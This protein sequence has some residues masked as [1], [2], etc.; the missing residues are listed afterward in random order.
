V[1]TGPRVLVDLGALYLYRSFS[2]SLSFSRQGSREKGKIGDTG[3]G[4]GCSCPMPLPAL[5]R[6][7]DIFAGG[8]FADGIFVVRTWTQAFPLG[9]RS[10]SSSFAAT[11][12]TFMNEYVGGYDRCP[13]YKTP[14]S[15]AFLGVLNLS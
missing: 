5:S 2:L 1:H 6:C 15:C 14:R 8:I 13:L 4:S 9:D 3:T 7:D 11:A 10:I 12:A